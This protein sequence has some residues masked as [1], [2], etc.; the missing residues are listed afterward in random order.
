MGVNNNFKKEII[1]SHVKTLKA[2][3]KKDKNSKKWELM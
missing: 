3:L 2:A 1:V